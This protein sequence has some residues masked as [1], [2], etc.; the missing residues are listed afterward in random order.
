LHEEIN[1]AAGGILV[2]QVPLAVFTAPPNPKRVLTKPLQWM[3]GE[4][5]GG[6]EGIIH[7][8]LETNTTST[9]FIATNSSIRRL[10]AVIDDFFN[11]RKLGAKDLI[12]GIAGQDT[13]SSAE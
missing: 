13:P 2:A 11:S 8:G 6:Y 4:K 10:N 5:Q 3:G 1:T 12:W 9:L 7:V